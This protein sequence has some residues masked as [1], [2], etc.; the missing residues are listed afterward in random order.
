MYFEGFSTDME[1]GYDVALVCENGHGINYKART[2]PHGNAKFCKDCGA[3]AISQCDCGQP[4]RGGLIGGFGYSYT[5]PAYCI[6]CGKPYIWTERKTDAL[7]D[8]IREL[9]EIE[10]DEKEKLI[11]L[12]PDIVADR[13]GTPTATARFGNL[14]GRLSEHMRAA[15]VDLLQKVA[16]AYVVTKLTQQK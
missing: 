15:L 10:A 8:W 12:V 14:M 1:H 4:I 3:R 16:V 11:A 9:I 13:P 6:G 5:P 2:Q 7:K